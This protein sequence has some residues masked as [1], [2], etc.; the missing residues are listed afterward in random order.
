M[1]TIEFQLREC[2]TGGFPKGLSFMLAIMPRWIYSD[3]PPMEAL[4]F[5]ASL[6]ELKS[7][8][9]A[10]ER[11][12]E[13]LLERMLLKN[14]HRN[15]VELKPDKEMGTEIT[16]REERRLADAK[17][18]MSDEQIAAVIAATAA[19]KEAQLKEDSA[20][21][22]ATI[23]SV[24]LADLRREVATIPSEVT[25]M[26][27]GGSLLTH[28]VPSGGVVYAD[29]LLDLAKVPMSELP[30]LSLFT[31]LL[32]ETGTSELDAAALQ[33]K[34]GAKTGGIAA[35]TLSQLRSGHGKIAD[36]FDVTAHLA[37]RG[38]GTGE[39]VEELFDLMHSVLVD[40]NL[41][42][43]KEKTLEVLKESKARLESGS[44]SAATGT[45]ASASARGGAAQPPRGECNGVSYYE[46][47]KGLLDTAENDWPALEAG[48]RRCA[49]RCSR[50]T[51]SSSTSPATTPSSPPPP[52]PPPPSPRASRRP[53]A[54][55]RRDAVA[56]GAAADAGRGVRS[57]RR[58][59]TSP[60]A[61]SSS[62]RASR[63][64]APS[65]PSLATSR[66]ATSGTT[67]ASSAARTA[68]AARSTR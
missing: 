42:G 13:G 1:N 63:W 29:V 59:T 47:L 7:K 46:T 11:V 20:D 10:G 54:P 40:A 48:S 60:R 53:P 31:R 50:R 33:R 61:R 65:T 67:C 15:C 6:A 19:L 66:A 52:P 36:P 24:G 12:F 49:P 57:R 35:S 8:L 43:A 41:G 4:A 56:R 34:I 25:T 3:K 18:A 37:I 44:S 68:A 64:T 14:G 2:N 9:A 32:V 17:A 27:G 5:E 30:L 58:S 23:P 45:P 16:Q 62:A 55:R 51:P 39:K 38:K 21:D 22:L 28:G 26:D